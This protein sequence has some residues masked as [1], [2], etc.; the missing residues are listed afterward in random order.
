MA[1]GALTRVARRFSRG[2][3][4]S[5]TRVSCSHVLKKGASTCIQVVPAEFQDVEER[6]LVR[7]A[8]MR[9]EAV[10]PVFEEVEERVL[11]RPATTRLPGL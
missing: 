2:G 10:P 11:V 1:S 6:V 9:P 4:A 7:P 3:A 8:T 5:K